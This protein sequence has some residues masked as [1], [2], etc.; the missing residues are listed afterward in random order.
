M[1]TTFRC[2][3]CH[4]AHVTLRDILTCHPRELRAMTDEIATGSVGISLD[5]L[6]G[7]G[8]TPGLWRR[9]DARLNGTERDQDAA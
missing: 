2:P 7:G 6:L 8:T 9:M 3:I 5:T 4:T 1:S